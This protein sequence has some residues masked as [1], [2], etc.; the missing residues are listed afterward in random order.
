MLSTSLVICQPS[1]MD[2][3]N[4]LPHKLRWNRYLRCLPS[5]PSTT[6]AHSLSQI[7]FKFESESASTFDCSTSCNGRS[8]NECMLKYYIYILFSN[9]IITTLTQHDLNVLHSRHRTIP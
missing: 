3:I 6:N 7:S 5:C 8:A 2:L 9:A 1:S 4:Y